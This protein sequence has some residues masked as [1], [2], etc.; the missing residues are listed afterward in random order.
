MFCGED[1]EI[2]ETLV[3]EVEVEVDGAVAF[4]AAEASPQTD[5]NV[6]NEEKSD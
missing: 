6:G 3:V 4:P 5:M 2:W 1:P